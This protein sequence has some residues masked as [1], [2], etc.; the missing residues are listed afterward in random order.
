VEA[1]V[2]KDNT[3]SIVLLERNNFVKEAHYKE[4][5]YFEGKFIDS[6]IYSLIDTSRDPSWYTAI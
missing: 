3:A 6:V 5:Y 2:D 1:N 4:N